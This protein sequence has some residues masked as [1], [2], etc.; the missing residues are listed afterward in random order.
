MAYKG[1]TLE[2][3]IAMG[4]RCKV[5]DRYP[6]KDCVMATVGDKPLKFCCGGWRDKFFGK[7]AIE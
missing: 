3:N 5:C 1:V 4:M 2:S 6:P 7:G